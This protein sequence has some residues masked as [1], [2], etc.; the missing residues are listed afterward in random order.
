M[1]T[2]IA[3]THAPTAAHL[4][5]QGIQVGDLVFCSGQLP[6]T[7]DTGVL[8]GPG[9]PQAQ[10]RQVFA[11]VAA[12]LEAA[13]SSLEHI[14]KTT[15]FLTD[16]EDIAAVNTV[17][18]ETFTG[19]KPARSCIAVR[20]LPHQDALVEIEVVATRTPGPQ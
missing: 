2:A 3:T 9:D 5:N 8:V 1:T 10:T 4:Y 6:L 15:I 16:I 19:V 18:A 12:V 13:G 20:A 14:V 11:N 17:Y 7:A